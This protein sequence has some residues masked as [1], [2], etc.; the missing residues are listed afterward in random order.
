[1]ATETSKSAKSEKPKKAK[2]PIRWEAIIPF[3]VIVLLVWAYFFFFF[4]SHLRR[5]LE[6]G[7]YQALGAEV[8]VR[9]VK[10]SFWNANLRIQGVQFTDPDRPTHNMIEITDIR[11]GML[12]DAL[13]RAKVVINEMAV[14]GI[15]IGTPRAAPGKVKPPEPIKPEDKGPS[16]LEKETEKLKQQALDKAKG[17]YSENVIGDIAA[18]LSGTSGEDQL[19][20]LEG[21]LASKEKIAAFQ[22]DLDEKNKVWQEKLKSLPK[23]QEIQSIGD[24]L[25]KIKTK[26]FKTPQEFADSLKQLDEVLKDADQKAKLIQSASSDFNSDLKNLDQGL[27]DLDSLIKKDIQDLEARFH[28]PKL[29]AAAISKSL[30]KQYLDPY[31]AK[32]NRYRALA[33]KY[34]PPNMLK[35]GSKEPDPQ[36]QP[37]P[38][39]K[40]VTYEFGRLHAY[41]AF[42]AK[43]I[44]VTSQAGA[45]PG[46]GDIEG[47]IT[48]ISS[49]QVLTG[50]PTLAKFRGDFPNDQIEKFIAQISFDN[51][52]EKSRVEFDFGVGAYPVAEKELVNSPDVQIK[53][54]NAKAMLQ[55]KGTLIGLKDLQFKLQNDIKSAQFDVK[56]QNTTV[57]EIL[58]GVF[59]GIPTVSVD[60][61]IKGTL[62]DV[63]VEVQS[64]L[65]PE[66]KKGFEV[67]LQKKIDEAKAKIQAYVN[68]QIGKEKAKVDGEVA[69]LKTQFDGE[70][71]KVQ[72]QVNA[73]KG[74][75]QAK[76]DESKKRFEDQNKAALKKEEDKAKDAVKKEAE[77]AAEDLK[78]KLGW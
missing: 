35:K 53:F 39:T 23:A 49:N 69:K 57:M 78:K 71:K 46:S 29:D 50:K 2:G 66:I 5:A 18:M 9:D 4:D 76:A 67:Q 68:E 51:T 31:L 41:P 55:S 12:W 6:F 20:N 33:E 40:G 30:F 14:E 24:R 38:R 37:H 59:A 44:S 1:M 26:D 36:I 32:I 47:L 15:K 61:D 75:A 58:K 62:P 45:Q 13:L 10:T 19:K 11:F 63:A 43:K 28:L 7:G 56:A 52:H 27:K 16:A 42:W 64:N 54:A 22:K 65:G 25:N 17:D 77:K 73:Q 48:D 74:Q 34:A 72:D 60:A 3:I 21:K 70:I 8:N